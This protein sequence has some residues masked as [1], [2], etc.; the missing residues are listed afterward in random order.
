MDRNGKI[1]KLHQHRVVCLLCLLVVIF[2]LSAYSNSLFAPFTLDDT[3]SFVVEPKVLN[4]TFS[5]PGFIA[6][7]KTKFGIS[8]FLPM[9]TFALDLQWGAGSL[10]AFHVTNIVIHFLATMAL[11]FMLS[12]LLPLWQ[13][14]DDHPFS[15]I[16]GI[17]FGFIAICITGIWSLN[18][19]QTN[20]VT[21]LVQ[22]MTSIAALFYFLSF[23]CYVRGRG[24][25]I[26]E[27]S[28]A[29]MISWYV[30]GLLFWLCAMMS[31]Q[32][33]ATLPVVLVLFEWLVINNSGLFKFVKK[34][35]IFIGTVFVIFVFLV[36]YKIVP[37]L[38]HGY[39]HRH[40][41]LSERLLT[42]LR[43]VVSYVFLL[44]MPLPGFL[45]FEHDPSLSTSF[46]SPPTTVLSLLFICVIIIS[47]WKVR[48]KYPLITFGIA[49]FFV[50]LLIESTFIPLE[51]MFE[52]RL[53]LPSAGF[54]LTCFMIMYELYNHFF[55]ASHDTQRSKIVVAMMVILFSCLSLSTYCRNMAWQDSVALYRDCLRKAPNKPRVHSNLAKALAEKGLYKESLAEGEKA[56]AL[57][58]KGYE[59]YWV[60]A[61]NIIA[62]L[63]RMGDNEVALTRAKTFLDQA[64]PWALNKAFS[65]FLCHLGNIYLQEKDYQ[66]AIENYV[67]GLKFCLDYNIPYSSTFEANII[68]AWNEGLEDRYVFKPTV[69]LS[70]NVVATANEKMAEIFFDLN[71]D[72]Q[73]LEYCHKALLENPSSIPGRLIKEKIEKIQLAN[74]I[75][76]QK[77]TI[78]SKY[79]KHPVA[80][81]FNFYMAT[82][83]VLLKAGLKDS[84][85]KYAIHEAEKIH[86]GNVDVSLLKSWLLFKNHLFADAINEVDQAIAKDHDYA[87]LWINRGIYALAEH[88]NSEALVAFNKAME[89]YPAYPHGRQVEAMII[90][91]EKGLAGKVSAH[92]SYLIKGVHDG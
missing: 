92:N 90:A 58:I 19:V 83:Y 16:K 11:F 34:H 82:S 22:R 69:G 17:P 60:A 75:Q 45:T 25:Q 3:H 66:L 64:P 89:L 76:R 77:G 27:K 72:D 26:K 6:L 35:K 40:F 12:G 9:V 20:A 37:G 2:I 67:K 10:M 30:A 32:I 48:K 78:K 51:L 47:V 13:G 39:D 38:L 23:G 84:L 65:L 79:L 86:P 42:E 43:I 57:G 29:K 52:H 50:N 62:T 56:L 71:Q 36:F 8:R 24:R 7:A 61:S 15:P 70:E 88:K 21:Y 63:S 80:S 68:S 85:V 5:L 1:S 87:Q 49:W 73:A 28:D 46:F 14:T 44:L 81:R 54:Y 4:F 55:S 18:P 41:T 91:A 33:A 59:V 74:M 31:K 53:Y